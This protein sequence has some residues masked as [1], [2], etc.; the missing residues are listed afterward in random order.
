MTEL[1][2]SEDAGGLESVGSMVTIGVFDGVH[3]A[4]R[5]SSPRVSRRRGKGA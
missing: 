1:I 4:T 5:R 3:T 2:R